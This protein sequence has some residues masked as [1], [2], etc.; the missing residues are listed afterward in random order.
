M[1]VVV[2]TQ[3]YRIILCRYA[4]YDDDPSFGDFY[5]FGGWSQP[6]IKQYQGD[7]SVCG[8]DIDKDWY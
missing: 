2:S 3:P 6:A 5:S 8:V 7:A 4:H 1:V